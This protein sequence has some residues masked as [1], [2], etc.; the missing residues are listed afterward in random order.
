MHEKKIMCTDGMGNLR[1]LMFP[2]EQLEETK[3]DRLEL[4]FPFSIEQGRREPFN[5]LLAAFTGV[6]ENLSLRR[7]MQSYILR[8]E[9]ES[10]RS[11][12]NCLAEADQPV[13]RSGL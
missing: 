1:I 11:V 5:L 8:G 12:V 10:H 7:K 9:P 4:K 3:P 6:R 13:G 2:Q